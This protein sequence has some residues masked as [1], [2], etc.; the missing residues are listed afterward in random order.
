MEIVY[1]KYF[2]NFLKNYFRKFDHHCP[3]VN[4]CINYQNYKFFVLFLGY[5]CYLCIFGFFSILPYF[6]KFWKT[7]EFNHNNFGRFHV[8]FL[9]FVSGMFGASLGCLFLYHIYLTSRNRT[10]IGK[11]FYK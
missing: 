7:S 5:G 2:I 1:C 6:I 11:L 10:T 8:M 9:F 3:W 4:T